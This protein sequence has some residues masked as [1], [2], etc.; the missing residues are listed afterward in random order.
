M[1]IP[2]VNSLAS[3]FLKKRFHQIELFLK[4]PIDVQNELLEHLL[5]TA[6]TP[7]LVNNMILPLLALTENLQKEYP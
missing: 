7:K 3:W 4:Y 1:P 6:K 5:H 2:I